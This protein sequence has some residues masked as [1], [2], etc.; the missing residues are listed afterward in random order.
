MP[1]AAVIRPFN[2]SE[3]LDA[4]LTIWS[5]SAAAAHPFI[6]GEGKGERLAKVRDVYFP[7]AE[8]YV[9]E[10][11]KGKLAGFVSLIPGPEN[12]TEIGGLFVDPEQ[13]G[14]GFGRA[15]VSYCARA[16]GDLTLEVFEKNEAARRFYDRAGFTEDS[17]RTDPETGHVLIR[18]SRTSRN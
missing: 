10:D 6:E 17:R 4:A 13:Q 11:R 12:T 16:K 1:D 2:L 14:S 8:S 7:I 18:K 5:A 15:L 3:D 9:I